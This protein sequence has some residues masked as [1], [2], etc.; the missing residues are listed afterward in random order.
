[1]PA[2]SRVELA[3]LDAVFCGT[4]E[5]LARVPVR[6]TPGLKME[7]GVR[8]NPVA[9]NQWHRYC[10]C[11]LSGVSFAE[12]SAF[13]GGKGD[14]NSG[15]WLY[16]IYAAFIFPIWENEC[17]FPIPLKSVRAML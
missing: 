13:E 6:M 16:P 14:A 2:A 12:P 5:K 15:S 3:D 17:A 8:L 9:K 1:M 10:H 7:T 11:K 4:G